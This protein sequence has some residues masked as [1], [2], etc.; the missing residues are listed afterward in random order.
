MFRVFFRFFGSFFY[1]L[2]EGFL[3]SFWGVFSEF[4]LFKVMISSNGETFS[5]IGDFDSLLDEK[6]F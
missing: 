5:N 6:M 4:F 3:G 1:S 2:L